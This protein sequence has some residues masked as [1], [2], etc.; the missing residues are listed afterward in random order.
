MPSVAYEEIFQRIP[1]LTPEE[2]EQLIGLLRFDRGGT[3]EISIPASAQAGKNGTEA[4]QVRLVP[5]RSFDEERK[6]ISQHREQYRGQFVA[7]AG[8]QLLAHGVA[9]GEVIDQA[10]RA[11]V[12]APYVT[13]IETETEEHYLSGLLIS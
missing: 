1:L 2:K 7:L 10:R 5:V 6:W 4:S 12:Q 9:E 3:D 11:G 13:Y 8:S